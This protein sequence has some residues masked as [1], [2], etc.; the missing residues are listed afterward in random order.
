MG[1]VAEAGGRGGAEG[2]GEQLSEVRLIHP[3][4]RG[5]KAHLLPGSGQDV[6]DGERTLC[7]TRIG[8]HAVW[9]VVASTHVPL[10]SRCRKQQEEQP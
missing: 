10:C 1:H 9:T 7:G 5:R 6:R 2:E 4:H 8:W 3:S